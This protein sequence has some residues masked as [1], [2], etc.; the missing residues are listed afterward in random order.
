MA[1]SLQERDS[2][3][4]DLTYLQIYLDK[5]TA[6]SSKF[7]MSS[8][9]RCNLSVSE[10]QCPGR[11]ILFNPAKC[12]SEHRDRL[13]PENVAPWPTCS[14]YCDG[15]LDDPLHREY[16]DKLIRILDQHEFKGPAQITYVFAEDR[17][18]DWYADRVKEELSAMGLAK[19][20]LEHFGLWQPLGTSR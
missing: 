16:Y 9:G 5:S 20:M 12:P 10:Y 8:N 11:I 2:V 7:N 15:V 1:T 13:I 14:R 19:Y 3:Q 6:A 17:A 4:Q 18:F